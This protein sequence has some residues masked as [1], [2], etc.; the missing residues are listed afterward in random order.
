M[1]K[2]NHTFT[3]STDEM[4]VFIGILLLSGYCSVSRGRMYWESAL[5]ASNQLVIN[6]MRRNRFEEIR[7]YFHA[8]DNLQVEKEDRFAKV[9]PLL[10]VMN[11]NTLSY[12][13]SVSSSD[14][15]IDA[16]KVP[17]YGR[18]PT[19]QF[20]R[21]KSIRWGYGVWV[22][23]NLIGYVFALE[24]YLGK[25]GTENDKE[26]KKLVGLGG[27]VVLNFIDTMEQEYPCG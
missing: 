25:Y 27:S 8:A 1:Q 19:K 4:R 17:Y 20:I 14:V 3:L 24:M 11:K 26:Y 9:K 10:N 13:S 12:G 6:S 5:D 23:A 21:G 7:K 16:S 22:A 15:S 18:H 2:G